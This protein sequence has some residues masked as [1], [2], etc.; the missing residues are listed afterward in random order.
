[1]AVLT[2]QIEDDINQWFDDMAKRYNQPKS[3]Y[4]KE[5]LTMYKQDFDEAQIALERLNQKDARYLTTREVE[6]ELGL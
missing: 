5:I 3:A 6:N 1:M 2:V 4:I